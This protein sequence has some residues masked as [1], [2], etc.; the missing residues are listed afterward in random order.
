M[1][2]LNLTGF[3]P[4]FLV[5]LTLLFVSCNKKDPKK[6]TPQ[7][8]LLG[9]VPE[10]VTLLMAVGGD[11]I[12]DS[13]QKK[14]LEEMLS[15][16]TLA[17]LMLFKKNLD[18]QK[19]LCFAR[20]SLDGELPLATTLLI[21]DYDGFVQ[22]LQ[23]AGGEIEKEEGEFSY[24][25]FDGV[26]FFFD[27]K[28]LWITPNGGFALIKESVNLKKNGGNSIRTLGYIHSVL[29][30]EAGLYVNLKSLT[31]GVYFSN[32]PLLK[33]NL[34][35]I[36]RYD[37]RLMG[38]L[39]LKRD[40]LAM[41]VALLD[42]K[43][44]PLGD[45]H[46]IA[47]A[48]DKNL[49]SYLDLKQDLFAAVGVKNR[50]WVEMLKS[51][52]GMPIVGQYDFLL[53]EI[54]GTVA[55]ALSAKSSTIEGPNSVDAT[56]FVQTKGETSREIFSVIADKLA[57]FRDGDELDGNDLS[58]DFPFGRYVLGFRDNTLYL[59]PKPLEKKPQPNYANHPVAST[60]IKGDM[61]YVILDMNSK[62]AVA[63]M[64]KEA[65]RYPLNG[66]ATLSLRPDG[67][68]FFFYNEAAPI[69]TLI[70]RLVML[71]KVEELDD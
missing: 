41:S 20:M 60:L 36:N 54:D 24:C 67:A 12:M 53:S 71:K 35:D 6:D 49:L 63:K 18:V 52:S 23:A 13:F 65:L 3:F 15:P 55:L 50:A 64:A 27:K 46:N 44:N 2:K 66:H 34:D 30:N 11:A 32:N 1:K 29:D 48:I 19:V 8:A 42:D 5:S 47:R 17:Q 26:G 7:M 40:K 61:G 62:G 28:Q 43:G 37:V 21:K 69:A 70:H 56:L 31:S 16:Q 39:S 25:M 59:A 22:T 4:L 10:D 58:L 51:F 33:P 38:S 57:P 68:T 45:K 9:T 14:E